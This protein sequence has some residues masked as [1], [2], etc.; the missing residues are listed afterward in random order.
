MLDQTFGFVPGRGVWLAQHLP[1]DVA[2][3]DG[4]AFAKM[5]GVKVGDGI[6]A[7]CR[8]PGQES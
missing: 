5:A 2:V 4:A 6:F 1:H 8:R 7:G 3:N